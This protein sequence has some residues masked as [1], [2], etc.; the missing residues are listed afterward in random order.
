MEQVATRHKAVE[1]LLA[2]TAGAYQTTLLTY[3]I[4]R[5]LFPSV[6]KVRFQ[7]PAFSDVIFTWLSS[8]TTPKSQGTYWSPSRSLACWPTTTSSRYKTRTNFD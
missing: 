8:S 2:M 5:D 3:M 4:Q 7:P 6:M 1:V